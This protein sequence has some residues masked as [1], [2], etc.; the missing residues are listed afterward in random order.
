VRKEIRVTLV[1]P[2]I[3]VIQAQPE[4]REIPATPVIP[5][6]TVR[7]ETKVTPVILGTRGIQVQP[8]PQ[9]ELEILATLEQL[10]TGAQVLL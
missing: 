4:R 1:I 10:A 5:E 9:E 6:L 3:L 8:E 2:E 7:K